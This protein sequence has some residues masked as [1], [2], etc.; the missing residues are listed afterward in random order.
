MLLTCS[1]VAR[2]GGRPARLESSSPAE[3][4]AKARLRVSRRLYGRERETATLLEKA[5]SA[6]G[7]KPGMLLIKGAPGVGKST[8]LGQLEA[9]VRKE[10]GRFISGKFDQYKRNVPYLALIQALQQLIGQL[11]GG[12]KDELEAWRSRILAAVGNNA[13]VVID[14]IPEL[15]L[16]TGSQPPVPDLPAVQ[17]RNR[18][19]YVFANLIQAFAPSDQLLCLVMDD[20]QWVDAA[21]LALLSH[22]LTDAETKNILFVGAYRDNEVDP[23]HP[24]E[25]TINALQDSNVDVAVLPLGALK[26]ADVLQLLR[27]TFSATATEAR[28]LAQI[29]HA[30]S[31]GNALYLSQFLPYLC[32]EGLIAF[33]YGS[34]K[35]VW[36]L[37]RI[38]QEGVTQDVLE[39]LN[40]RLKA[41]PENTRTI[42]A[43]AACIGSSFEAAK[44]AVAAQR[45]LFEVL[46]CMTI[47]TRDGLIV[48]IDDRQLQSDS[49]RPLESQS[50]T[51]F[52]FLHDRVQEA[53]FDCITEEAKKDF[54][55]QIGRRLLAGLMRDEEHAPPALRAGQSQLSLGA[56][57]TDAEERQRVA[58]LNLVAG[59]KARQALAYQDALGYLSVGLGLLGPKSWN[60][61]YDLA[62]ELHSEAFECEYLTANF[63]RADQLFLDLIANARSKL[64]KA[65]V[66]HTKILLDTSEARYEQAITCRHSGAEALSVSATRE[67][68]RSC[69]CWSS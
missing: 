36:D 32:D 6:K 34:G 29:L 38:Q 7:G 66:Y 13:R 40:L 15:E 68:P 64:E 60:C 47:G 43:T 35:W 1:N 30:K 12:T 2:N 53:A 33:D 61:T 31:G 21:S 8:L 48:A 59:R 24:L 20:L 23:T 27:D 55:L 22:V 50:T 51:R 4:D 16:I 56:R 39:L 65:R 28:D 57:L 54:R 18:F 10:N 46:Q 25:T 42:L 67:S 3:Y 41:L 58:R 52:R 14:V 9:F 26:E 44:V 49:D 62:F 19:N 17:T 5:K 63:E 11:L 69:I 45:S 37:V